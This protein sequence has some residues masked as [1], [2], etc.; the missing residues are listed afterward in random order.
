M[1][2]PMPPPPGVTHGYTSAVIVTWRIVL[3]ALILAV[4]TTLLGSFYP[5]WTASRKQIVDAL[6]HNR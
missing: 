5:A 6:R 3:E 2:I 4:L 1:G